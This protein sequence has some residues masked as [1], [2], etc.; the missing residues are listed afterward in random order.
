MRYQ[1][2][3]RDQLGR[4]ALFDQDAVDVASE[5]TRRAGAQADAAAA[6]DATAGRSDASMAVAVASGSKVPRPLARLLRRLW[7]RHRLPRRP[8]LADQIGPRRRLRSMLE[9]IV[10]TVVLGVI[11]AT[12]LGVAIGAVVVTLQHALK[13]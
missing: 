4:P 8:W 11:I 13:S 3:Q 5:P 2:D 10:I 12:I 9:I 7:H 1:P 6:V